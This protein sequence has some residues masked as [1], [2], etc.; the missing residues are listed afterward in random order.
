[1][2]TCKRSRRP[3][4][5]GGNTRRKLGHPALPTAMLS[6]HRN[7]AAKIRSAA[8]RRFAFCYS[9]SR[10]LTAYTGNLSKQE[11]GARRADITFAPA[12]RIRNG[13]TPRLV[14][15]ITRSVQRSV[16]TGRSSGNVGTPPRT[17]PKPGTNT[18]ASIAGFPST[19]HRRQ[20][21]PI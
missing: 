6:V 20:N 4:V 18:L 11:T 19:R 21:A 8:A 2:H 1:M 7:A 10:P 15:A 9:Y 17:M 13:H 3:A 5:T 12:F 16:Y 14:I